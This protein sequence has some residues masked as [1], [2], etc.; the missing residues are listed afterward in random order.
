MYASVKFYQGILLANNKTKALTS[1]KFFLGSFSQTLFFG[2]VKRQPEI[3]LRSQARGDLVLIQTSLLFIC[4]SYC[5]Y[6][7]YMHLHMKSSEVC[8]KTRSTPASLPIRDQVTKH[9][10]VK[11]PIQQ[12]LPA[13]YTTCDILCRS[14]SGANVNIFLA[15]LNDGHN[16]KGST[17]RL[18]LHHDLFVGL[19][20]TASN[21]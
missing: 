18:V 1:R 3:R 13:W 6:A 21:K 9:T 20:F 7:N 17:G 11:W 10:T 8:I 15:M 16:F 4:R 5:S 19:L 14:F 2:G 12:L